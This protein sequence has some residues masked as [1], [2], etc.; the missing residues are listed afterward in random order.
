MLRFG[1]HQGSS[2]PT[3]VRSL[4]FIVPHQGSIGPHQSV[5]VPHQSFIVPHLRFCNTFQ[6]IGYIQFEFSNAHCIC[7]LWPGSLLIFLCLSL[8][9]KTLDNPGLHTIVLVL[10]SVLSVEWT[11]YFVIV[12]KEPHIDQ[13][14][15]TVASI[16]HQIS[17]KNIHHC[18][19]ISDWTKT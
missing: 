13:Q 6:F 11:L 9:K 10:L 1:L 14:Q 15:T 2:G 4:G 5:I 18:R 12:H 19:Q 16:D 17:K 8:I 3:A 7:S